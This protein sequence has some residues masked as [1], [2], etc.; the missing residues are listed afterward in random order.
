V[1][2]RKYRILILI[3]TVGFLAGAREYL[4]SRDREPFGWFTPQGQELMG[5]LS[6]VNP[7]EPDVEFLRGMEAFAAGDPDEFF[8]RMDNALATDIK[9]NEMFLRTYAQGLIDSGA[10]WR[11]VSDAV[12]RWRR[13]FP[14]SRETLAVYLPEGASYDQALLERALAQIPWIADARVVLPGSDPND[15]RGRIVMLFRRGYLVDMGDVVASA[16]WSQTR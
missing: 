9:H 14:F 2:W 6:E 4:I 5:I 1:W 12:N 11:L 7:T 15:E 8:R 13:N 16:G 3:Y 10:D